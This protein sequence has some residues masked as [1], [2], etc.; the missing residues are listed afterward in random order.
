MTIRFRCV[1]M[2]RP[3]F[4]NSSISFWDW[5]TTT[6]MSVCS[7]ELETFFQ[8][9]L[10]RRVSGSQFLLQPSHC[11]F[12]VLLNLVIHPDRGGFVNRDD[13]R[14]RQ[15][16]PPHVVGNDVFGYSSPDGLLA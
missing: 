14:L 10:V 6:A 16:A 1:A 9:G 8:L 3:F 7:K 11:S 13:H 4:L 5:E 15:Y 2:S 12:P